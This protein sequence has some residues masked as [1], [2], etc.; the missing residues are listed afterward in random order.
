ME[1]EDEFDLDLTGATD[2]FDESA[3]HPVGAGSDAA[4]GAVHRAAKPPGVAA[5]GIPVP[6]R[7]ADAEPARDLQADA[8]TSR[9]PL[10][11]LALGALLVLAG[12]VAAPAPPG[13]QIGII[14]STAEPEQQWQV[15]IGDDGSS[16]IT[17]LDDLPALWLTE[18]AV[19]Y[20]GYSRI[21]AHDLHDGR[22]IWAAEGSDLRCHLT[23]PVILCASGSGTEAELVRLHT[24]EGETDRTPDAGLL[25]ALAVEEDIITLHTEDGD[26]TVTRDGLQGSHGWSHHLEDEPWLDDSPLTAWLHLAGE[27]LL[28]G[29]G[30][31]LG[32]WGA[33]LTAETGRSADIGDI[34]RLYPD[35]QSPVEQWL[36]IDL[37]NSVY[38]IDSEGD[39]GDPEPPQAPLLRIDDD[40][41]SDLILAVTDNALTA[42]YAREEPLWSRDPQE[43]LPWPLARLGDVVIAQEAD[44]LTGL[45]LSTGEEVWHRSGLGI[46]P[47]FSDGQVL[48][49]LLNGADQPLIVG[50]DAA[51][52]QD[53][54]EVVYPGYR[55]FS[56]ALSDGSLAVLSEEGLTLLTW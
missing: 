16:P 13:E 30:G 11:W 7:A 3:L 52:G 54:F 42:G 22:Q 28:V 39:P 19:V 47:L 23:D 33:I 12:I 5:G 41:T 36:A 43:G 38:R 51:T 18:D 9:G 17:G 48:V 32:G 35:R 14:G 31:S 24:T 50:T 20:V 29:V 37:Y 26:M 27:K 44:G 8:G 4:R 15:E 10:P 6:P 45:D 25:A 53:L 21:Q 34:F 1:R 2:G 40:P 49:H 46:H 55:L 56:S